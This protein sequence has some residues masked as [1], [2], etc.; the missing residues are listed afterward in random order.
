MKHCILVKF[1]ET[2]TEEKKIRLQD[3]IRGVFAPLLDM[4][5]IH[6]IDIIP[7][8]IDRPNR[9]DILIRI[10]MDPV[11]LSEYDHSEPHMIWK[12]EYGKYVGRKAIF[13]YE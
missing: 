10:D 9:Y 2:V 8:V 11:T 3:E 5:G 6:Q 7:N 1:A 12:Q 4:E 13:D